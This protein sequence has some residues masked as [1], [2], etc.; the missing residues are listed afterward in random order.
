M[1]IYLDAKRY[2]AFLAALLRP[3]PNPDALYRLLKRKAPWELD[4]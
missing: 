1:R 4:K 3:I 2:R